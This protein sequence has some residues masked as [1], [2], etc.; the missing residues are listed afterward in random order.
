MK[1]LF[2]FLSFVLFLYPGSSVLRAHD[3]LEVGFDPLNTSRLSINGNLSQN[4]TYFPLGEA[5]SLD[6]YAFPGGTYASEL[7]FSAFDNIDSPPGNALVRM[8]LLSVAGPAGGTLSFW[9]AGSAS[10]TWTRAAGWATTTGDEPSLAASEDE[11]GYGHIHG[12]VF[13]AGKPGVYDATFQAVDSLGNYTA[14]LPFVV[15][16][17]ALAP[18]ALAVGLQGANVRLSFTGRAGLTYDV[19][20]STTLQPGSWSTVD[21]LDGTGG[22]LEFVEPRNNR[23]KVFY[24]IVEY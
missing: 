22:V 3:H 10:A 17:T 2:L 16:F 13:T 1:H 20:S 18:P 21:T 11:T 7:T 6:L 12:R 5:P 24:R 15:R 8:K 14:S 19:Q 23:P 4:A 9:E